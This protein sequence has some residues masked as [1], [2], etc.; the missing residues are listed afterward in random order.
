MVSM[1]LGITFLFEAAA[2]REIEEGS[3]AVIRI[4]G[5]DEMREFNFVLLK[6]SFFRARLMKI[7]ELMRENA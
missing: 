5:F 7:Y 6:N 4:P 1:D 3:L 2:R